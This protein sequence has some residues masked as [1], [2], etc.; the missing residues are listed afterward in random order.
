MLMRFAGQQCSRHSLITAPGQLR[1][2]CKL[3]RACLITDRAEAALLIQVLAVGAAATVARMTLNLMP[4][5]GDLTAHTCRLLWA[6][7]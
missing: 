4:V 3:S 7:D 2:Y 5:Q 1:V 6:A